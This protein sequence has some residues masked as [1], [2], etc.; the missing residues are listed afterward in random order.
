[1]GLNYCSNLSLE[2]VGFYYWGIC[3]YNI[4]PWIAIREMSC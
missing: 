3:F 4:C 1:M 2:K